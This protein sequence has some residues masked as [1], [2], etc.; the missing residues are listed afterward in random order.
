MF[1][2][3]PWRCIWKV[4]VQLSHKPLL[5]Y[6]YRRTGSTRILTRQGS[7]R[8]SWP[9][10]C[11]MRSL[12]TPSPIMTK[13]NL[14]CCSNLV[15]H[16]SDQLLLPSGRSRSQILMKSIYPGCLQSGFG[17]RGQHTSHPGGEGSLPLGREPFFFFDSYLFPV[18]VNHM[19]ESMYSMAVSMYKAPVELF[20]AATAR[21]IT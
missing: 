9:S 16:S 3:P 19:S 6:R 13:A 18:V 17:G 5:N 11:M 15:N 8:L 20:S 21:K 12:S 10:H 1:T 2:C 14:R 4:H 7:G